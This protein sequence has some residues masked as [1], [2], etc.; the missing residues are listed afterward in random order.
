M[1]DDTYPGRD[2]PE[3]LQPPQ[4][5]A[6]HKKKREGAARGQKIVLVLTG[7]VAGAVL[8]AGGFLLA[9]N[10]SANLGPLQHQVAQLEHDAN[11]SSGQAASDASRI[12]LLLSQVATLDGEFIVLKLDGMTSY[13]ETC[14]IGGV[15]VPC[16]AKEPPGFGQA[17]G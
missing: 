16:A 9:G 7:V 4:A 1:L 11:S 8:V 12:K 2:I 14:P 15:W 13:N 3:P 6:A 5:A 17:G 10:H